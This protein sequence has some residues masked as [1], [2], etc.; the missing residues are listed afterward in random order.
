MATS[1][2]SKILEIVYTK[3]FKVS[4]SSAANTELT[5]SISLRAGTWIIIMHTPTATNNTDTCILDLKGITSSDEILTG[6]GFTTYLGY[7]TVVTLI[8]L[9]ATRSITLVAGSSQQYNWNSSY[10]NR[11]GLAAIRV[12]G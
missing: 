4:S 6:T 8:K 12:G 7:G 5:N 10:L 11:G 2:I 1:I 9:T 3:G